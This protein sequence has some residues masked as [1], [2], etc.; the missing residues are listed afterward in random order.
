MLHKTAPCVGLMVLG[1]YMWPIWEFVDVNKDLECVVMSMEF[2]VPQFNDASTEEQ[3]Y[4]LLEGGQVQEKMWIAIF[5]MELGLC[6]M[7]DRKCDED[8]DSY[9]LPRGATG[10]HDH[11]PCRCPARPSLFSKEGQSSSLEWP[12]LCQQQDL[13]FRA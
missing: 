11:S 8:M 10:S 13:G 4:G 1:T 9:L 7:I 5:L 3:R 12:E 6:L 2:T